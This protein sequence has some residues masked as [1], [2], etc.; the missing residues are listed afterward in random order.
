M[1]S[2]DRKY[3]QITAENVCQ[4]FPDVQPLSL[5]QT[6]THPTSTTVHP[7]LVGRDEEQ[8]RLMNE[9]CIVVDE[10]ENEIGMAS[11]RACHLLPN[12]TQGL[13]HR[14]F[15]VLLFDTSNRLLLQRR[16]SEKI[17]WPDYWTNTCC[18][19]PLAIAGET[20]ADFH[21]AMAGARRAA[22]RKLEHE[23]GI[24]LSD[25]QAERGLKFM[26]RMQY[27]CAFEGGW[28]EK[29][30]TY[31]FILQ[32]DTDLDINRNE[33]RDYRYLSRE[34]FGEMFADPTQ[35]F[36]PWFRHMVREFLPAWWDA[37]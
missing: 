37:L 9:M 7:E 18:S 34:E 11:K 31:I 6:A 26:T 30:V 22:Q 1:P 15:S 2:T 32:L 5:S 36:T 25:A 35:L 29:E 24:R 28:G 27:E 12:I 20:G 33:I 19:H 10:D 4:L 21:A 14:A 8:I 13:L 16:A 3:P 23:L 17:T